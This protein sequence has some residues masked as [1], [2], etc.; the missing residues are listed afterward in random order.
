MASSQ[1]V[2]PAR[3]ASLP[4]WASVLVAGNGGAVVMQLQLIDIDID[5]RGM[6][7]YTAV[8]RSRVHFVLRKHNMYFG[9][10][11]FQIAA[12]G[13]SLIDQAPFWAYK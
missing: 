4:R 5:R 10:T 7:T 6:C 3:V 2:L 12:R 13:S 1:P 8:R 9:L 11:P